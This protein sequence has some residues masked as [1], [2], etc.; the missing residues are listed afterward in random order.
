MTDKVYQKQLRQF[1]IE[2]TRITVGNLEK[3]KNEE[4]RQSMLS[5]VRQIME[6]MYGRQWLYSKLDL[7]GIFTAPIVPGD[8]YGTHFLSGV[9]AIGHNLLSDIMIAAPDKFS[10]MAQ[11]AAARKSGYEPPKEEEE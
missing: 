7:C 2:S 1:G 4:L 3:K 9:Q 5:I 11:E 8:P 6:T 10:L